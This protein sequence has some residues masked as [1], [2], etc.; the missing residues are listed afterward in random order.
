MSRDNNLAKGFFIGFLAGGTVGAIIA[1]LTA[2]KSGKELRA[3]IKSRSEE[4]LDEAEK[5]LAEAKDKARELI[6]EGKKKSERIILDARTKSE[7]ILKDAEKIFKDAKVKTTDAYQ[8]GK[9]KIET[10]TERIKSSVKAG[11][12]AYKEAKNS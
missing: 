5:Y 11:I 4:Y 6:N 2:P 10:E 1:L 12:D 9:E 8:S 3:D 7:D